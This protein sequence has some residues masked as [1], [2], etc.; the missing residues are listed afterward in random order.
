[1]TTQEFDQAVIEGTIILEGWARLDRTGFYREFSDCLSHEFNYAVPTHRADTGRILDAVS[2][3]SLKER[4][5]L[6]SALVV[7]KKDRRPSKGF[8]TLAEH[9]RFLPANYNADTLVLD[10]QAKVYR[11]YSE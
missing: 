1:M 3:R 8:F 9:S 4:D 7:K 11:S 6:L 2:Q 10:E 5:C